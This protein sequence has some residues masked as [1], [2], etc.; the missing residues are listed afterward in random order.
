MSAALQPCCGIQFI[1]AMRVGWQPHKLPPL[2][3]VGTNGFTIFLRA[4]Q[5][6]REP[7]A[8]V[9][10]LRLPHGLDCRKRCYLIEILSRGCEVAG[11]PMGYGSVENRPEVRLPSGFSRYAIQNIVKRIEPFSY[12]LNFDSSSLRQFSY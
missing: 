3:Y 7:Q 8:R 2:S 12:F 1:E 6:R 10:G 9:P 5:Q 4:I 11:Q